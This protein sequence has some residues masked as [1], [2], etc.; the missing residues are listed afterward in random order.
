[1]PL[2]PGDPDP[3]EV[4]NPGGRAGV[5]L[6]CEH[7][8]QA[9]PA[10]LDNLGLPQEELDRHIGWDIGAYGVA[11]RLSRLI[12]APLVSQRYSRLVVDCNRPH[13]A[14]THIPEVSDGTEVPAN[15]GLAA[16]ERA[17][18]H[19]AIHAPLHDAI[20]SLLDARPGAVL[21]A[22]HSFT[23][24]LR[25]DP[26]PRPWDVGFLWR[27]DGAFATR[28]LEAM[29]ETGDLLLAHNEPY[30]IDDEGDYTIPVHGEARRIPHVL[31][32]IRN[33]RIASPEGQAEFAARLASA[34]EDAL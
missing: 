18:R 28:L 25:S 9:V 26:A 2:G 21:V 30:R 7:A 15:R 5:V 10:S 23:P 34:L 33:D 3:V 16:E 19:A 14:P 1:M 6:T 32:E 20:A 11:T 29:G 22:I 13:G 4:L 24:Q 8:G 17:L 12:D 31:L 27:Q